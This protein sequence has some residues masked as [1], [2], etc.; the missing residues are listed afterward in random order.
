MVYILL[1]KGFEEVEAVAPADILRRGGVKTEFVSVG[2]KSVSGAHGITV[3]ADITIDKLNLFDADMI[4]VP[5]GLGGV[6]SIEGSKAAMETVRKAFE[7]GIPLGAICAGPR[8]LGKVGAL[9]GK[10]AV[11]YP[12]MDEQMGGAV[13]DNSR[14]ACTDGNIVTGRGPG[15]A[16]A[17][18][19]EVLKFM[20]GEAAAA[21][22]AREMTYD[23]Y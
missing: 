23:L 16:I 19:L 18:G 14:M 13:I 10:N 12:G 2:Q 15:A 21:K 9:K 17:F 5:G 11:C 3:T 8:V 6:E 22:V 7:T 1:G 20:K 4:I